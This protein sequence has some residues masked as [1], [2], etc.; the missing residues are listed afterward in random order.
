MAA[1]TAAMAIDLGRA[2]FGD[3]RNFLP[4]YTGCC[5]NSPHGRLG[6][7]EEASPQDFIVPR[8]RGG[9]YLSAHQS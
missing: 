9:P 6:S 8:I 4:S 5:T 3:L 2:G 1:A 7:S